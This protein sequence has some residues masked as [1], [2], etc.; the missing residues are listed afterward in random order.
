MSNSWIKTKIGDLT[1]LRKEKFD[2]K[3]KDVEKY[4]GL[5]HIEQG[6]GRLNGYGY[7]SETTSMKSVF[8]KEDILFGKLR[9]YLRKYWYA[10]FKGVCAT[11]ILPLIANQNVDKRF[12][13]YL[14]QQ[15]KFI[16]FLDQKSFGTKMPR[17]SWNE[18]KE[19]ECSVPSLLVEQQKIASIL[20]SVDEAIEKTEAVMEKTE[21]V[22]QGLMQQLLTKGIGHTKFKKEDIGEIPEEWEIRKI[23]DIGTFSNGVSKGAEFFGSGYLFVNVRE[24]ASNEIEL[25]KLNR[26]NLSEKELV[27]NEVLYGDILLIRSYGNPKKVGYPMLFNIKNV[28]ERFTHSGFTMKLRPH[29]HLVDSNFLVY[30]LK[31]DK[32]RREVYKRGTFSA[33]NNINQK[34][35]GS[36]KIGL[37]SIKEQRRIAETLDIFNRKIFNEKERLTQLQVIKKGL[38]QSLL[39]GKV[40]VN[41]DEAEVTQV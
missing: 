19:Y 10:Q 8:E 37:P 2:P 23:A 12:L 5:E 27:I 36:I 11:E 31:S 4:I 22:K 41:V 1:T 14:L 3:T 21:K 34:E 28:Q 17:T 16:D 24:I 9:P 35:Y 32:I 30:L 29:Q 20:S 7:S 26:V 40:R 33:N 13:F 39:T 25:D 15:D 6:T 38:M 18:I